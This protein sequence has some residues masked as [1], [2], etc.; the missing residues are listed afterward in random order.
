MVLAGEV[1][2]DGMLQPAA[3]AET[4][5]QQRVTTQSSLIGSIRMRKSVVEHISRET[6]HLSHNPFRRPTHATH[7]GR[8]RAASRVSPPRGDTSREP[9]CP[10]TTEKER[11]FPSVFSKE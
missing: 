1:G 2:A 4:S 11:L 7:L 3:S 9:P 8:H 10:S 5:Q 6:E